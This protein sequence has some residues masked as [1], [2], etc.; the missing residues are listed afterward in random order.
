MEDDKLL[1]CTVNSSGICFYN[2]QIYLREKA[3]LLHTPSPLPSTLIDLVP[4]DLDFPI[5]LY[6]VDLSG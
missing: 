6:K 3:I 4:N 2:Q 1:L 5:T